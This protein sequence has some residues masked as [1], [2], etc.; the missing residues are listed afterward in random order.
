M[1]TRLV[2]LL[3]SLVVGTQVLAQV[4]KPATAPVGQSKR[5]SA[6]K[7]S[8]RQSKAKTLKAKKR[9]RV[10]PA[11]LRRVQRAFVASSDLRPMAQ[12]LLEN[13]TPAA[14]AGVEAYARKHPASDAGAL[15]WFVAGYSHYRDRDFDRA[16]AALKRAQPRAGELADYVLYFLGASYLASGD[17][18]KAAAALR[19]FDSRYPDSLFLRD[20]AVTYARALAL[21]GDNRQA[22]AILSKHREPIRAD[23]E[24]ALA[25][26]LLDSGDAS[27]AIPILR[28]LYFTMPLSAE[29]DAAGELLKTASG[30]PLP[31]FSERRSRA[32][33]LAQGR[34][35]KDALAEY[36]SLLAEAP[37]ESVPDLEFAIART[38]RRSGENREARS[39]LEQ[40]A[41]SG[42]LNAERLYYLA[43]IARS[44]DDENRFQA[45][46]AQLRQA[47]PSSPWLEQALLSAG[48]MYLLKNDYDRAIDFYRE[49]NQRFPQGKLAAY[50]HWK[51][52]WLTLRQGRTDQARSEFEQQIA[53]YP[54][55]AQVPAALYWR[56]RIAEDD[57]D[58][59]R[60]WA[61][62][63]RLVDR[64]PNYYYADR[65]RERMSHLSPP[66][67]VVSDPLLDKIPP[68][69][70][71]E[72]HNNA[73][74]P[75]DD[76]R[77]QKARL[78]Q[79]A[80]LYDFAARELQAEADQGEGW[81]VV[82]MARMYTRGGQ[83][84]RALQVLK[85]TVPR[86]FSV[87][88]DALPRPYWESLFPR[89]FW[90]DLKKFSLG[91]RLDPFLV[92]SLIRQESEFNPEAVSRVNAIGL[93]QV[94]PGTGKQLARQL[95]I[96][97]FSSDQ[98]R[99]PTWNL[100]LGT[101]YFRDLLDRFHGRMEYALAA[102][103]AGTD[104][105]DAWLANGK[106][107]DEAEFVESI[108]FTETREYVQA[109]LRNA[110]LYR[111][112]YGTP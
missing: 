1:L 99:V 87:D 38:L 93:M 74:V 85:R 100:Q 94:L 111:K 104:R 63:Q 56:A 9:K 7:T 112:L 44:D 108:P 72:R 51:A 10:S 45:V 6:K 39:I 42:E 49:L 46:L 82:E 24:L 28:N 107:R 37:P 11:R 60:A 12:Q 65:A 57:R 96:R 5:S 89:A 95:G 102:Y 88:V 76:L 77:L 54:A 71:P 48:N 18:E 8:A 86:Y 52:A 13:P 19:E 103:N 35:F 14:Y 22:A 81:A 110:T 106:Y 78:L 69:Q 16:V 67:T 83:Y 30:V 31:S 21:R 105:V 62:Y 20:A 80:A 47:A 3:L 91:N 41:P 73:E 27:R 26:A 23:V 34:R 53:L 61:W 101:R 98:L 75:D 64:F 50:A 68:I 17:G 43:D 33:L 40:L 109:I 90:Q 32:D 79:N 84:Y 92:A 29:A 66:A 36:R 70:L 58:W 25:R 4:R 15:A 97:R 59:P 55:S 2:L